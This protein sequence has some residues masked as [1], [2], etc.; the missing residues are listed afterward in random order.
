MELPVAQDIIRVTDSDP[1]VA[2]ADD[3]RRVVPFLKYAITLGVLKPE[4][5]ETLSKIVTDLQ[6]ELA[7]C[8]DQIAERSTP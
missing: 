3:I 4:Q 5:T 2:R 8:E 7:F 6:M 1:Q